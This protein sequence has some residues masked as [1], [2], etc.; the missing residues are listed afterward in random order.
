VFVVCPLIADKIEETGNKKQEIGE[1]SQFSVFSFQYSVGAEKKSVMREY[2]K[3]SKYIFPDLKIGYLH[4]RM[5]TEEKDKTMSDFAKATPDERIDI[6]VSTSVVEVGVDIPNASVMMIEGADRFG[7]AQLHQFR[8]RVGRSEHQSYCFL[9]TDS[10]SDKVKN[11]LD[12]FEKNIDGFKVAEY[13]LEMRGPGEVYGLAQ[14]GMMN[15]RLATMKDYDLIKL[16]RKIAREVD[17]DKYPE[18]KERVGE[19]ERQ[20]HLE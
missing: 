13:D 10:D 5:K 3:L 19:W 4:G 1:D 18:L 16:A 9:F 8:G 6:L 7:L 14:S 20:V 17:F 15:F 12:F 2:E 11:R